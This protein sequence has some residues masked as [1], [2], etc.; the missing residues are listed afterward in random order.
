MKIMVKNLIRIAVVVL[1]LCLSGC[2]SYLTPKLG[3]V[4]KEDTIIQIDTLGEERQEWKTHEIELSFSTMKKG[5]DIELTG[6]LIFSPS[7]TNTFGRVQTFYI[8]MSFLDNQ[9]QV[10]STIDITPMLPK[11]ETAPEKVKFQVQTQIPPQSDAITFN[12]YGIFRG[13]PTIGST[14]IY[15]SP[16]N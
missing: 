8:K 14:Q 9:Q 3:S 7:L 11:F 12:Y 5:N 2:L 16:F 13:D 15:Y 4:A 6:D 1:S 10:I